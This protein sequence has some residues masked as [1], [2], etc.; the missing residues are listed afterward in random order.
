MT[1]D[2]KTETAVLPLVGV[3]ALGGTIA[4]VPAKPGEAVSPGLTA[5]DLIASAPGLENVARLS[6]QQIANVASPSITMDDLRAAFAWANLMVM[7]QGADGIVLTHGTDTLEETAYLLDL[8]WEHEQPIVVTGAM[9]SAKMAGAD[10]PANLL[11]AVQTAASP[12]ARGLGVLTC[13]NDTVHLGSRVVKSASMAVETFEAPGAGPVGRVVEGEF[14]PM[15]APLGRH[16]PLPMPQEGGIKVPVIEAGLDDDATAVRMLLDA[17][18]PGL[19]V[20]GCGV[21]HV[22]VP[23]ADALEEAIKG[24]IPVVVASRTLRGGTGEHLYGYPGSEEDLINR[25]IIMGGVLSA[26]KSRLLLHVLLSDGANVDRVRE[27]FKTRG[28]GA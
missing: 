27:E 2:N 22:S 6:S 12:R 25:G 13:L 4:M 8:V 10:G 1:T 18:V 5:E 7:G 11:A 23:V 15:W 21:G 3:G 17:G 24:S 20:A 28:W 14:R 26:R 19:V 9:R 16:K